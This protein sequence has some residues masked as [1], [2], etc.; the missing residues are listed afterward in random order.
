MPESNKYDIA[1][2]YRIYP[3][4]SKVPPIFSDDKFRL[5]ELCLASFA[6][7]LGN[8]KAKITVLFDNCPD[9]YTALFDKHLKNFDREYIH[10]DGIGNARTFAQQVDI[11]LNQN[12]SEYVFFAEDDYFYLPDTFGDML[13]FM[14]NNPEAD[15]VTPFDH[16]DYYNLKIHD[17]KSEIVDYGKRRWRTVST[18]CMTFLATKTALR[19]AKSVFLTYAKNN[20]D[21]SIWMSLTKYNVFNLPLYLKFLFSDFPMFKILGKLWLFGTAQIYFGRKYKLYA[22]MPSIAAHMDNQCPAPIVDWDAEF[23]KIVDKYKI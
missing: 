18:T 7:A 2:V 21:A 9:E 3:K 5:S 1:I 19:A 23:K 14:R 11:L 20:Y 15:F 13:K 16:W 12:D 10:L 4:V 6:G 17:Y 8:L 22:P